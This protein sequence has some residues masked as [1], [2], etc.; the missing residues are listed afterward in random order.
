MPLVIG[1][2]F[3]GQVES[4]GRGVPEEWVGRRVGIFP[5]IPCRKCR[6]CLSGNY[7][8]CAQYS[9]LGS[10]RDG[11]FAEYVTVPAWNLV[12]LP[13]EVSYEQAAMLEPMAVAVHAMRRLEIGQEGSVCVCGLGTI[14][15]LLV[16]FLLERGIREIYAVGKSK[17]QR[18]AMLAL[19]LAEG[20][21]CDGKAEDVRE[22]IGLKTGER[23]VDAYFECVGKNET[24]ALGFE[25][26]AAGG[27]VC[28]VGNPYTDMHFERDTYWKLLRRQL[29]V[30]GTWNSTYLGEEDE[31]REMD[32]WQYV[33][34]R[35]REGRVHPE[36]LITHRLSMEEV[37]RGFE[38][39][40]DKR[41]PYVKVMMV[42]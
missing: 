18:G 12:E 27:K 25:V 20:N 37:Y 23:G 15:Q 11:A 24:A 2:E 19:G 42:L 5:L 16:M 30:K 13:E 26:T 14:G 17:E 22:F 33:L 29:M 32:D 8:M 3:S 28:M 35:I 36:K 38:I 31:G 21:Y 9:Y 40:R 7:E 10:R 4:V 39:M 6:A 1:H 34:R 41:E